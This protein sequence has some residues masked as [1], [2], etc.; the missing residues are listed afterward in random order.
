MRIPSGPHLVQELR[1]TAKAGLKMREESSAL[2]G[3]QRILQNQERGCRSAA[4]LPSPTPL[5]GDKLED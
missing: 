2:D 5:P 3:I 1:E 4:V